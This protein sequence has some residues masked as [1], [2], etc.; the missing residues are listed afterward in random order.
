ML[1]HEFRVSFLT[2]GERTLHDARHGLRLR[3]VTG[4]LDAVKPL[5]PTLSVIRQ[6]LRYPRCI[7]VC[8]VSKVTRHRE[9]KIVTAS[10]LRPSAHLF[11]ER[12]YDAFIRDVFVGARVIR[13]FIRG[14]IRAG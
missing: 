9:D 2:D 8:D 11:F 12:L 13:G 5:L 1:I 7:I 14:C 10:M 3:A 4:T 6:D